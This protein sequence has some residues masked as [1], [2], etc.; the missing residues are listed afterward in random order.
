M[1]MK[2][3]AGATAGKTRTPAKKKPVAKTSAAK[4]AAAKSESRTSAAP[5]PETSKRAGT[6]TPS[7]VQGIGWAPFRYPPQ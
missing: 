4:K 3:K 7:P 1:K 5:A 2:K 6:Y